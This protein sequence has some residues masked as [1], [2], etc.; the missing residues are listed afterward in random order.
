[1]LLNYSQ[2]NPKD[3][4][5]LMSQSV[6]PRPI[7]WI[8]TQGLDGVM[9]VAPFSYFIPLSSNPPSLIVSI[10]HKADGTPKDTL[11][12]LR[13]N[14]KCT[15]CMTSPE[16]LDSMHKSSYS[17]PKDVGEVNKLSLET[18]VLD[19][20]FPPI[21]KNVPTAFLCEFDKEVDLE[22]Q[23]KP[24]ILT[25]KHHYIDDKNIVKKDDKIKIEYDSIARI[26]NGY[27]TMEKK[28]TTPKFD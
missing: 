6:I 2:Q 7:A 28:L 1:M 9:N 18:M 8:V 11:K 3:I 4:Y 17:Y 23:T 19:Q 24:I 26:S 16:F 5:L 25:I 27:A 10:G 22:G 15:I 12:N 13:E 20:N 21:I 14:K